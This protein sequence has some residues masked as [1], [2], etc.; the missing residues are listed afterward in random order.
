MAYRDFSGGETGIFSYAAMPS[1]YSMLLQNLYISERKTVKKV[2][3]YEKVNSAVGGSA[4]VNL[5]TG[6]EF[7]KNDGTS[8]K[9]VS[10]GGK[11]FKITGDTLTPIE[12]GLD[13]GEKVYFSSMNDLCIM[14]NG[15]P[16][17]K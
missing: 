1:K 4:G 3:G 17:E 10:G 12:T 11:I 7:I 15:I 5:W 2:P 16:A 9:L 8:I 6:F 14:T 13:N